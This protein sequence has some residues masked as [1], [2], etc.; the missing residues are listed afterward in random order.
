MSAGAYVI[1]TQDLNFCSDTVIVNITEPATTIAVNATVTSAY[2]GED[3]SCFGTCDGEAVAVATGGT[4]PYTYAWSFNSVSSNTLAGVCAG[5]YQVVTTDANGCSKSAVVTITEPTSLVGNLVSTAD[6]LCTN[7]STGRATVNRTGGTAPY[8]FD[9]GSGTQ[10]NGTFT[11]LSAGSYNV[12]VTDANSCSASIPFIIQAP[13]ALQ[14]TSMTVNSN[15]NGQDVTCNS[16]CDA[17]A[18]VVATGGTGAYTFT[19]DNGE[20]TFTATNLCAGTHRV[21]VT[22]QNGCWDTASIV[23]TE[24]DAIVLTANPIDI[25]CNGSST[26][27]VT[28]AVA[29]GTPTYNYDI[30][31]GNQLSPTFAGLAAGNYCVTVTDIN[32]CSEVAC[33]AISQVAPITSSIAITTNF[34]GQNVSCAT[35][36]DAEATVTASGSTSPYTYLWDNGQTT[37]TATGLGIGQHCVTITDVNGCSTVDCIN[38]TGPSDLALFISDSTDVSCFGTSTGLLEVAAFGGTAPYTYS[39][40]GGATFTNI[41]R[42]TNLAAGNYTILVQDANGCRATVP[43]TITEPAQ[44]VGLLTQVN[45][46]LCN[47]S[48]EGLVR[49]LG[50]GGVAPHI[51]SFNGGNYD[52]TSTFIN[53]IAGNYTIDV[54][55]AN[56]CTATVPVTITEPAQLLVALDTVISPSCNLNTD[57][58]IQVSATQASA[59]YLFT[60]DGTTFQSNGN[61]S[62]LAAGNYTASVTDNL[63]CQETIAVALPDAF[64]LSTTISVTSNY[65]GQA[66]SCFGAAD[67]EVTVVAAGGDNNFTY[68]WQPSGQTG[69]VASGLVAGTYFLTVTDGNGCSTRDSITLIQPEE[70]NFINIQTIDISCTGYADGLITAL[71]DP[72]TGTGSYQYAMNGASYSTQNTFPNLVAGTYDINVQDANG[73]VT[74]VP[75]VVDDPTPLSIASISVPSPYNGRQISCFGESD[76]SAFVTAS[77]GTGQVSYLWSP[78]AGSQ[79]TFNPVNLAAGTHTVTVTDEKG[80]TNTASTT[81][82]E[83]SL[84]TST[85]T[86]NQQAG[87]NGDTAGQVTMAIDAN[88]GT[89]PYLFSIDSGATFQASGT[90]SSLVAGTYIV[91]AVDANACETSEIFVITDGA[92]ITSSTQVTSNF[93]GEDLSCYDATD[94]TA[95]VNASGGTGSYTYLWSNAATAAAI[96]GLASGT[97]I[98]EITDSDGC[99]HADSVVLTAPDTLSANK[100]AEVNPSCFGDANGSITLAGQGG[101]PAYNFTLFA[102]STITNPTGIFTGLTAGTYEFEVVDEN[103]CRDTVRVSL[104]EPTELVAA[105]SGTD[106]SCAG[107]TDAEATATATGGAPF[108]T[109]GNP[110]YNYMWNNGATTAIIGNLSFGNYVVTVTDANGCQDTSSVVVNEKLPVQ[111][112]IDTVVDV[113]CSSPTGSI[114]V[115]STGGAG[116]FQY[117]ND[118]G[119]TWV[120]TTGTNTAFTFNNLAGGPYQILVRDFDNP[121]CMQQA[122][123]QVDDNDSLQ[124]EIETV[125]ADCYGAATGSISVRVIGGSGNFIYNWSTGASTTTNVLENLTANYN[126]STFFATPYAVSVTDGNRCGPAT[127]DSISINQP[128]SISLTVKPV[129]MVSCFGGDDGI[130]VASVI[131][132]DTANAYTLTW[133]SGDVNTSFSTDTVSGLM[134][135]NYTVTVVD[136]NACEDS[137][138]VTITEPTFPLLA[139]LEGDTTTCPDGA[140]GVITIDTVGGGTPD[141][142]VQ[143]NYY[144]SLD[145][146]TFGSSAI[147][148]QGLPA[149]VYTV[150]VQDANACELV[151]DSVVM[152]EPVDIELTAF[153][154]Q[155]IQLGESV[156]PLY[157]TVNQTGVDSSAFTW[158][159]VDEFGDTTVVCTGADCMEGYTPDPSLLLTDA[160]LIADLNTGCLDTSNVKILVDPRETIFVPNAFTP[161]GDGRNDVFTVYAA[162]DVSEIQSLMIFNRWG[163]LVFESANFQPGDINSGWDGTFKNKQLNT[164]V[165]VIYVKYTRIDGTEG[166]YKSDM[167]LMR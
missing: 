24:P 148:S 97:Y 122:S 68:S 157:A 43:G 40:N 38:V 4:A 9:L 138:T 112:T 69:A 25:A 136:A 104:V 161:N 140:D 166:T 106:I 130:A 18:T 160:Y 87:C 59:P 110:S 83:P 11:N 73:C 85:G 158:S 42:Y 74:T 95:E 80:C 34:N 134:A 70:L 116:L 71:A 164:S 99:T 109:G 162:E 62:G 20:T 8:T 45:D 120:P 107:F 51:Y 91:T 22:D 156:A 1:I 50:T 92:L 86:V 150:Y 124:I 65:N 114:T 137:A 123:A 129:Q 30:G 16:A 10:S 108:S 144:Y 39:N 5:T 58:F 14:I 155:S 135:F 94:G 151:V 35:A 119:R 19:W 145:G 102:P 23:I 29:G 52:T 133:D 121:N 139:F 54:Q 61:F 53:L 79:T 77:G 76:A 44:V 98:V 118:A 49:I 147:L 41:V 88:T 26:G 90:F 96:T 93:N 167:T 12:T 48:N 128:D 47:G 60:I 72:N 78:S 149:G 82:R 131:G 33:F 165:F 6:V 126:D 75:V 66:I 141:S 64:P 103:S 37:A 28:M 146:L 56:G 115:S 2:N 31:N 159:V 36:T 46:V 113:L 153:E 105:A 142:L 84:L 3:V 89:P 101:V 17:A 57:G 100:V 132:G 7:D 67:G 13:N 81:I 154:S 111:I 55:D 27:E 143:G 21:T 15:Y 127:V 163:E 32:A 117:S 152:N 125:A 63:G